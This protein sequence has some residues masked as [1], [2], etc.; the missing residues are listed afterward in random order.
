[1]ERRRIFRQYFFS[2]TVIACVM[3]FFVGV[4]T[5]SQ[6]TRYNMELTDY[7]KISLYKSDKGIEIAFGQRELFL[8]NEDIEKMGK[9][10][11]YSLMGDI[12]INAGEF[13]EKNIN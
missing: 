5:V 11:F 4:I 8:A 1:M 12:F 9:N 2:L 10:A 7:D 3:S 6:R 13:F